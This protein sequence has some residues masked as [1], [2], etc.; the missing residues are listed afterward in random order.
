MILFTLFRLC[1]C[2]LHQ[3]WDTGG[4]ENFRK[5]TNSYYRGCHAIL[6]VYDVTDQVKASTF[7]ARMSIYHSVAMQNLFDIQI[8]LD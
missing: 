3:Q 1:F 7:Y 5:I 8:T 4:Q 6:L 2:I